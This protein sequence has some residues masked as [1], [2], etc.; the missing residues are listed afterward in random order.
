MI[1]QTYGKTYGLPVGISRCG[2]FFGGGDL[3]FSRIVPGTIKSLSN[4]QRPVIRSDGTY[5]R[6][7]IYVK[8]AVDAYLTLL[9]KTEEMKFTGEA[10]NFSNEVQLSVLEMVEKITKLMGKDLKP[11]IKNEASGEIKKQHLSA[12]KAKKVLGWQSK[13]KIDDGLKE[14]IAWYKNYFSKSY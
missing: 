2:N 5:V 8:D 13:W 9:E 12:A 1:A 11:T 4:N 6:D 14:T 7:Y 10:F 3:N